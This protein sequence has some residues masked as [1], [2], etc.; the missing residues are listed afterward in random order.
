MFGSGTELVILFQAIQTTGHLRCGLVLELR[1]GLT[2]H[3]N[4]MINPWNVFFADYGARISG[5]WK[6]RFVK[7]R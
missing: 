7:L 2:K 3:L 5:K 1:F 4:V 6:I